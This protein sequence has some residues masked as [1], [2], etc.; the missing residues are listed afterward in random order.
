MFIN[1]GNLLRVEGADGVMHFRYD[2][3]FRGIEFIPD[4]AEGVDKYGGAGVGFDLIPQGGDKTVHAAMAG[5]TG[6]APDAVKDLIAG[7]GACKVSTC[8]YNQ[9]LEC[10]APSITVGRQSDEVDCLT[11]QHR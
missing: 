9:R 3:L 5:K 7:V 4:F 1:S 10:H 8:E 6:I 11:F 2:L